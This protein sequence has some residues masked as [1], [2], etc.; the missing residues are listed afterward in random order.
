MRLIKFVANTA[1]PQLG[2]FLVVTNDDDEILTCAHLMNHADFHA[3]ERML[4]A[5]LTRLGYFGEPPINDSLLTLDEL[6]TNC[7]KHGEV[8]EYV[9]HRAEKF[10]E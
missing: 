7:D 8:K 4:I 1:Y 6:L 3:A 2:S 5:L 9:G 10:L